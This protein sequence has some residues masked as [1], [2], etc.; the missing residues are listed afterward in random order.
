MLAPHTGLE[1]KAQARLVAASARNPKLHKPTLVKGEL[2]DTRGM[3]AGGF[4]KRLA[5]ATHQRLG[6]GLARGLVVGVEQGTS[7]KKPR[8]WLCATS[9]RGESQVV[10]KPKSLGQHL[11][12]GDFLNA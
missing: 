10:E 11:R 7:L 5:Q 2:F 8:T 4:A 12:F 6:M 1:Q 3:E 9:H